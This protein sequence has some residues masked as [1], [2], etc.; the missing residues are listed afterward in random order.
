MNL[1]DFRNT[2]TNNIFEVYDVL[3]IDAARN[4]IIEQ[5]KYLINIY[6]IQVDYRHLTILA[7]T[8]THNGKLLGLNWYG[9]AKMKNSPFMLASFEKTGEI[10]FDAA[11]FG[12]KDYL[13]GATEKI[14]LG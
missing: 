12:A 5:V 3:G 1:V 2:K 6:G 14:I 9:I 13:R 7:D 8:M 4:L 10:L 11:F